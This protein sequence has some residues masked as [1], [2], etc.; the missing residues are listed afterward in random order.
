[1]QQRQHKDPVERLVS[2]YET[3]L[4][5]VHNAADTAERKTLPWLRETLGDARERAVEL[6][7]LTREE[8]DKVSRYVER[9]VRE[10]AGFIADTGQEFRDWWAFD[11]ALIQDRL[12]EMLSGMAD[13]TSRALQDIAERAR[14][15]STYRSGEIS[16]P[17][18]LRCVACGH[19]LR[20]ER[21]AE[22][23]V[24]PD[25]QGKVFKR[26]VSSASETAQ[27]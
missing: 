9:D 10:A 5:R 13:A 26:S 12:L 21:A 27:S 19:L 15:A 6:G 11:K 2:A 1:M 7:E 3:M 18:T 25:C 8:A 20:L 14:E 23:P 22:I 16:A 4:E 17:G 24:C